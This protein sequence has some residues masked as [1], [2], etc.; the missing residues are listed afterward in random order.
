M[1]TFW[2]IAAILIIL[3]LAFVLPPL[4]IKPTVS[5]D[6]DNNALNITIYRER[7]AELAQENLMPEQRAHAQRELDKTL[8]QEVSLT[9]NTAVPA[10]SP[11]LATFLALALPTAVISAYLFLGEPALI[12]VNHQNNDKSFNLDIITQKLVELHDAR[13]LTELAEIIAVTQ[14][15]EWSGQP[16]ILLETALTIDPEHQKALWLAGFAA[17]QNADYAAAI[18]Y[19][20]RV[21]ALLSPEE[22]QA[23]AALTA[24]I[25]KARGFLQGSSPAMETPTATPS[26]VADSVQITVH[27]DIDP[28]LRTQIK[29]NDVVFIYVRATQGQPM[30]LAIVKRLAS[31]LPTTV[32]LDD[33]QAL[34]TT[35][36]L[37][38]FS[39][40]TL[41]AR[42]SHSGVAT[43]QAGDLQGQMT[44]AINRENAT[45]TAN[46]VINEVLP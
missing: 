26:T 18:D 11:Y 21:L 19:W 33:S 27:V 28:A 8:A 31:E 6:I 37:A 42:I 15:N 10:P 3:A 17:A 16:A 4:W 30:P 44:V 41:V 36:K 32:V 13:L 20:Q 23:R 12:T 40:V 7:L 24:Q 38:D 22:T 35:L 14:D 9:E 25:T 2:I 46:L 45:H 1:V 5:T 39:E 43:P 34:A 29:P